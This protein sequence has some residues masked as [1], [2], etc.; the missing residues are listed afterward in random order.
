[1]NKENRIITCFSYRA[2]GLA[3]ARK[4]LQMWGKFATSDD[5]MDYRNSK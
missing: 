1:M 3:T 5:L 2:Q 4:M